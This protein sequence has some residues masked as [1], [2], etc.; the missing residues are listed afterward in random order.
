MIAK[1]ALLVIA[2]ICLSACELTWVDSADLPRTASVCGWD[3]GNAGKEPMTL[4][5]ARAYLGREP[6]T[7]DPN[8]TVCPDGACTAADLAVPFEA[9]RACQQILWSQIGLDQYVEYGMLFTL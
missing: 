8:S 5:E 6:V 3:W 9:R 2:T 1:V 7:F 4:R